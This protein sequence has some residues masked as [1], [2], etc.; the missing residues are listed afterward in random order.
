[1]ERF[2]NRVKS[3]RRIATRFD[4]TAVMFLGTLTSSKYYI[5]AETLKTRLRIFLVIKPG[6]MLGE[7]AP[8]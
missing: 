5:V 8:T 4:K 6:M 2:F 7:N 3:F 1:M